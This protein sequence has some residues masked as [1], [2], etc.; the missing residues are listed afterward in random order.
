MLKNA[1]L[2]DTGKDVLDDLFIAPLAALHMAAA[3]ED[4]WAALAG[5]LG[6]AYVGHSRAH[7]FKRRRSLAQRVQYRL[8][9]VMV[10]IVCVKK[11][12]K[13]TCIHQDRA[14]APSLPEEKTAELLAGSN[15]ETRLFCS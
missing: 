5:A 2:I 12:D 8:G 14:L 1:F 10:Q 7:C 13:R 9:Q 4:A 11:R 6:S 15:R 3:P